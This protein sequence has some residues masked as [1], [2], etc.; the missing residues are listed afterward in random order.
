L[1]TA[2][3]RKEQAGDTIN[4]DALNEAPG[5]FEGIAEYETGNDRPGTPKQKSPVCN[6][7]LPVSN[8]E[9][10]PRTLKNIVEQYLQAWRQST[11]VEP[12]QKSARETIVVLQD[13]LRSYE[14]SPFL[15]KDIFTL[16]SWDGSTEEMMPSFPLAAGNAQLSERSLPKDFDVE[17]VERVKQLLD[18][19]WLRMS[20]YQCRYVK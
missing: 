20:S 7:E 8:Q 18:D 12:Y 11:N 5:G 13:M 1:L 4:V 2:S 9:D 17:R 10:L 19:S 15:Q 6:T 3:R 14:P 16:A